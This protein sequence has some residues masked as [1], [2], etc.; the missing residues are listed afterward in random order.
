MDKDKDKKNN[1]SLSEKRKLYQKEQEEKLQNKEMTYLKNSIRRDMSGRP[2]IANNDLTTAGLLGKFVGKSV[3]IVIVII[4]IIMALIGSTLIGILVGYIATAKEVPSSLF[5][6]TQQTSYL[7]D[8]NGE[9]IAALTG[10]SNI[11]RELIDYS[12]VSKTYIDE[13]F[14]AIEDRTFNT[15]IGIDPRRIAGAAISTL[16][17]RGDSAHGGSTIT[18]QTVKMLTGDNEVSYQ[19]KVQ[20]WYRAVRLTEQL[21]KN[22]IMNLYLD[23]VPMGNNYVGV[24]SAAKAY[25]GKEAKDLNL[26]ECALL[27]GIPKSPASYNPRTELG[28]KNIQR[29]QRIVLQSMLDVG[30]ITSDQY[31]EA[32]NYEIVYSNEDISF[33]GNEINSYFEEFVIEQVTKDLAASGKYT[34]A[35][36]YN[37]VQNGGLHIH[38]SLDPMVQ[39]KLDELFMRQSNFQR[40]PSIYANSPEKPGAGTVVIDSKTNNIVAMQGGAGEKKA[41]K[42][43]NRATDI[44]R[45]PGSVIK[46]LAVYAPAVEMD[47][48]TGATIVKDEPV[49][50]DV[51]NPNTEWPTNAYD[52]YLGSLPVRT[53][54]KISN[55][56]PAVKILNEVGV[57]TAKSYLAQ[58]GIDLRNDPVDLSL[59]TGSLSYGVSPLQMANGFQ[60]LAN[61]GLYTESKGYTQ[62]LDS[63]GVVILEFS[64][65]FEQVFSA[66]TSY[67]MLKML[68]DVLEGP[69]GS[70][71]YYGTLWDFNQIRN[72]N[73]QI[74]RTSAKTGTSDALQDE[75]IT[76]MTPYYTVSNWFGFDNKLKRSYLPQLDYKNQHYATKELFDY[77]HK[78]KEAA[79]WDKPAGIVE[80]YVS[81]STGYQASGNYGNSFLEYFKAGSPITPNRPA[82]GNINFLST[83]QIPGYYENYAKSNGYK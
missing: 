47:L 17:N 78:D 53:N 49:H 39:D 14:I 33:T 26:A 75:W 72:S 52:S 55:N 16:V 40:D 34:A 32:I 9:Q 6:I 65:D 41:N 81:S 76:M 50:M 20:E 38:T 22:K 27:A 7:Y 5:T 70:S 56:V 45:Q 21:P 43:L 71:P 82:N 4:L 48:I 73:G 59:A 2:K 83:D 44:R 69:T 30:F 8:K 74:I 28:R 13:A 66:E 18:Q 24:G 31:E 51:H 25:F 42:V 57:D 64:P 58:M 19:R 29:R 35:E 77:I 63:N 3:L 36:A 61:G 15:N 37:L 80:F 79:E 1:L 67:M 60:T 12:Q 54:L 62:V 11:N 68:E 10:D 46:P 23:L